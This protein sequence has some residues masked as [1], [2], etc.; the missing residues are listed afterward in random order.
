MLCQ[1]GETETPEA[2]YLFYANILSSII[3]QPVFNLAEIL[4]I[5]PSASAMIILAGCH[6]KRSPDGSEG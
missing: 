6:S 1:S 2:R 4:S 5:Y 3:T